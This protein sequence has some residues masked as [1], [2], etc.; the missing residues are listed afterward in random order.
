[1]CESPAGWS[2]YYPKDV[3]FP[4]TYYLVNVDE[5]Y[6]RQYKLKKGPIAPP[7]AAF[8]PAAVTRM[9]RE[10]ADKKKA[11]ASGTTPLVPAPVLSPSLPVTGV[12]VGLPGHADPFA[13][14]GLDAL[15]SGKN[16]IAPIPGGLR[17]RLLEKNVY[18]VKK[19][20][21][22]STKVQIDSEEKGLKVRVLRATRRSRDNEHVL[23]CPCNRSS[24][25]SS[26]Q[27]TSDVSAFRRAWQARWTPPLASR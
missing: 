25:R 6:R 3:L 20:G 7:T 1:M 5:K 4:D 26:P 12:A 17:A 9:L 24:R 27:S 8:A 10:R 22:E 23:T 2:T 16:M 18:Q 14:S 15:L 13:A 21:G 11:E 19:V